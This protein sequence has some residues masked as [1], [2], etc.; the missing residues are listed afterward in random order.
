VKPV[1]PWLKRS[2]HLLGS[3]LG[4]AGVGFVAVQLHAYWDQIEAGRLGATGWLVVGLLALVYGAA[5][6][7]LAVAWWNLLG[8]LGVVVSK[9]WA[10]RAYGLSQIAKYLPGNVFHLAGRQALG[11]TAGLPALPLAR[12][13]VWELGLI[14]LAGA[15]FLVLVVP[16]RVEAWPAWWSLAAF[17][18][19]APLLVLSGRRLLSAAV[20]VV[21]SWQVIFLLV[22]GAIFAAVLAMVAPAG[23]SA[24]L[25]P[26]VGGAY[27]VAW[28]AGLITPGAPAGVGV[29]ELV[30]LYLFAAR[31][32]PADLLIAVLI[33]RVVTVSG[34]LLYF[35]AATRMPARRY[36]HG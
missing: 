23:L 22:S 35:I 33:A 5:N 13:A 2:L 36:E 20:A 27:V 14:A 17:G 26:A 4:I 3:A 1:Q 18:A 12:S 11:M 10:V 30:L 29:R 32:A 7:M 25:L 9:A 28:L 34:D 31:F 8:H 21:L 19:L 16:L 6:L 15:T 24:G